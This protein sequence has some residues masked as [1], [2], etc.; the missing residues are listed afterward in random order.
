MK[1]VSFDEAKTLL[2]SAKKLLLE[3]KNYLRTN[4][5]LFYN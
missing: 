4:N 1:E 3:I 2:E 5:G